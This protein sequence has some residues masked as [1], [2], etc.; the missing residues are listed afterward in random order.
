MHTAH[1]QGFENRGSNE[2]YR[3]IDTR[4]DVGI[5]RH[6]S[7]VYRSSFRTGIPTIPTDRWLSC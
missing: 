6:S 3:S 7:A 5:W 4:F 1:Y 2:R